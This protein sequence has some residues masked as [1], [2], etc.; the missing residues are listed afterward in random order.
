MPNYFSTF[1]SS[2]PVIVLLCALLSLQGCATPS[3]KF[4]ET[5]TEL[6]FS[7]EQID[8][9]PYRH[10][11]FV[12][13]EARYTNDIAELHVYLDGDGTPWKTNTR[14]ADDPTARNPLILE[15]MAK[16]RSPA[17]L[18]GRPCY[19]GLNLS[20]LCNNALWTSDRYSKVVVDSMKIALKHWLS[21]KRINRLV[22][23][24]F[25]GGGTLAALLASDIDELV[26]LIT[27]AANLDVK[28]WS[29]YHGYLRPTG[30]LNPMSDA[31]IPY[32]VRQ[33]HLAGLEDENVP[34]KVIE[35]FSMTQKNAL[36]LPQSEYNHSCC[37]ADIWPNILKT[38]LEQ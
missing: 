17:I 5:A 30:S 2:H 32:S 38:Y 13:A 23:I 1:M 35:A 12:N 22:L 9:L 10:R 16:D 29:D 3:E 37:W 15:M 19:Y 11:L 31:H 7:Q 4:I 26:T 34:A 36:Y 8:G 18:L 21:A 27:V 25:S 14:V 33:I 28:A 20:H 6:G 24:G